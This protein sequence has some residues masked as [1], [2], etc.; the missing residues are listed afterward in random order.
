MRKCH[1]ILSTCF[2]ACITRLDGCCH[3]PPLTSLL[4][5]HHPAINMRELDQIPRASDA[6]REASPLKG[7]G[8][9]AAG[10]KAAAYGA[11]ASNDQQGA[12]KKSWYSGGG[13]RRRLYKRERVEQE[14]DAAS[15][16]LAADRAAEQPRAKLVTR[17]VLG[18]SAAIV[19]LGIVAYLLA[20]CDP[21]LL[22]WHAQWQRHVCMN[23][24]NGGG[25]H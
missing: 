25:L 13:L 8:S 18:V 5:L 9:G 21:V 6:S 2:A 14:L 22:V 15:A 20:R 23:N 11:E 24:S 7:K 10:K 1:I 12:S 3:K 4:P 16:A 19:V 17:V